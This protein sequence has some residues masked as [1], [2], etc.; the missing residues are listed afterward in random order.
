MTR[1]KEGELLRQYRLKI[2]SR[3]H[4]DAFVCVQLNVNFSPEKV[5]FALNLNIVPLFSLC[6]FRGNTRKVEKLTKMETR[7]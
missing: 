3:F 7:G 4:P 2:K 1:K 6:V 5:S